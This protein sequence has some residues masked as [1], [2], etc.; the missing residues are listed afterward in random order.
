MNPEK[1]KREAENLAL[2]IS[3]VKGR[4][5]RGKLERGRIQKNPVM[6]TSEV[7]KMMNAAKAK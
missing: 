6:I 4:K 7:K 1:R 3:K 5:I 2:L